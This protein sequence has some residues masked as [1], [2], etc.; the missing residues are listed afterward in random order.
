MI[1]SSVRNITNAHTHTDTRRVHFELFL[2]PSFF[3]FSFSFVVCPSSV[4]MYFSSFYFK[5]QIQF[6]WCLRYR[7]ICSFSQKFALI[8]WIVYFFNSSKS[9]LLFGNTLRLHILLFQST[10]CG[11]FHKFSFYMANSHREYLT[12]YSVARRFFFFF[13]FFVSFAYSTWSSFIV[14]PLVWLCDVAMLIL[15]KL[16]CACRKCEFDTCQTES[17]IANHSESLSRDH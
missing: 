14:I 12:E 3:S 17:L 7:S 6:L 15:S 8:Y 11:L 4:W 16:Y 5:L 9:L 2:L 10:L 1:V 13:N